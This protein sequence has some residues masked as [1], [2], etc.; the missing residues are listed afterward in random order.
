M[1]I[2]RN[3]AAHIFLF[4]VLMS[5]VT[6]AHNLLLDPA[7]SKQLQA[8]LQKRHIVFIDGIANELA[9]LAGNYFTDNIA[10]IQELGI[11][12]T[13]LSPPSGRPIL[14]NAHWLYEELRQ[15][16]AKEQ[17]PLILIAH[18]KGGVEALLAVLNFPEL[19][20]SNIIEK[21][22]LIQAAIG[23]AEL[24]GKINPFLYFGP[25]EFLYGN[26]LDSLKPA[27]TQKSI[28]HAF[29]TFETYLKLHSKNSK[30]Y[31]EKFRWF[32]NKVYFV[33]AAHDEDEDLSLG[34]KS[35]LFFC[36]EGLSFSSAHDGILHT[37]D[38]KLPDEYT[39]GTDLGILAADHIELVISGLFAHSDS[40]TRQAF[41]RA[42]LA[43]I[44]S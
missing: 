2:A 38:Q 35:V 42:L 16:Y 7:I 15:I 37:A 24:I 19:L 1:L 14:E 36:H 11:G 29:R 9:S 26:G 28:Q 40:Q 34:L 27:E 8:H 17:Q 32:S 22:V 10:A 5:S 30:K 13:H 31:E 43:Q 12:H 44:Y 41:T 21:V 20:T 6:F 23:G 4:V 3:K 39:F 33:R 25:I 18:S